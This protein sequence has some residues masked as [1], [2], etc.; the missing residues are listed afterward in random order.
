[1]PFPTDNWH[2]DFV[3]RYLEPPPAA[4]QAAPQSFDEIEADIERRRAHSRTA[5]AEL[6]DYSRH[7]AQYTTRQ[8]TQPMKKADYEVVAAVLA[9]SKQR[10]AFG[11]Q[12][13]LWAYI[14]NLFAYYF[15]ST[16][17]NFNADRFFERCGADPSE[18]RSEDEQRARM[19]GALLEAPNTQAPYPTNPAP[20]PPHPPV[21]NWA[22][23]AA[24]HIPYSAPH[25]DEIINQVIDGPIEIDPATIEIDPAEEQ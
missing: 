23:I 18:R 16:H 13:E 9:D 24:G 10:A 5:M 3:R 12:K 4:P 1:M 8:E 20:P 11:A 21:G 7:Y 25:Y 2:D 15:Q 22:N 14:V 19:R 17:P 6:S